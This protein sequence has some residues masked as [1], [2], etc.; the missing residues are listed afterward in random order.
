MELVEDHHRHS[1]QIR[2][3]LQSTGEDAVGDHLD[4]RRP[5]NSPVISSHVPN[6]GAYLFAEQIRHPSR[7]GASG[8]SARLHDDNAGA[9]KPGL[10]EQPQRHERRLACARL[11]LQH[12]DAVA[13]Q[14]GA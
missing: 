7:R 10:V 12:S 14:R 9:G 6:C 3:V 8:D 11:R 5:A 13:S 1:R 2:L 4:P